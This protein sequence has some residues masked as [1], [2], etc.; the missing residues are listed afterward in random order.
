MTDGATTIEQL[1]TRLQR[2]WE[3]IDEAER[4][5]DERAASRYTQRWL[6]LLADYEQ[7]AGEQAGG[8]PQQP[9]N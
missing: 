9:D 1:E 3:L 2:G 6:N 5:S 7:L 4:Q 8:E